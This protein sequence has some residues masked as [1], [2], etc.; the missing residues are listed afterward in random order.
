ME[1]QPY[2]K[3]G[4]KVVEFKIERGYAMSKNHAQDLDVFSA[5]ES[6]ASEFTN[7]QNEGALNSGWETFQ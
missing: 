2:C 6:K 1:K 5:S 4:L 3:P 7:I